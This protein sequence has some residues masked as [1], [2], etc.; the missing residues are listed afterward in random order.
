MPAWGHR[1]FRRPKGVDSASG[2]GNSLYRLSRV[3]SFPPTSSK[4]NATFLAPTL[5]N[6]SI[7]RAC[8]T[9]NGSNLIISQSKNRP[10]RSRPRHVTPA[11]E[12]GTR[13]SER[14]ATYHG[15]VASVL[16]SASEKLIHPQAALER[17]LCTCLC[18]FGGYSALLARG[19]HMR[20]A[21]HGD[22]LIQ[23]CHCRR[24][25]RVVSQ[26][27]DGAIPPGMF[28]RLI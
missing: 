20:P 16:P 24:R 28:Q 15:E 8:F 5:T 7:N 26:R 11:S 9:P 17:C 6:A 3:P 21:A 2:R 4:P 14:I 19:V 1:P 10:S 22:E 13:C 12:A 27:L 18:R 25:L 23:K